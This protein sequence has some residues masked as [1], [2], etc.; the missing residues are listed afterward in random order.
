MWLGGD[1]GTD[2]TKTC[3]EK[4]LEFVLKVY[5]SR[6]N[7]QH[8]WGNLHDC[9]MTT[10]IINAIFKFAPKIMRQMAM[11]FIWIRSSSHTDCVFHIL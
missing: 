10:L 9:L 1:L 4:K 11:R 3:V 5:H 6:F 7:S 2:I 8:N